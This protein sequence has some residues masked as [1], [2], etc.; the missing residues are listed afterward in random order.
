MN[1]ILN[2]DLDG[3]TLGAQTGISSRG[4]GFR[5]GFDAAF[6]TDFADGRGHFMIGGE[7]LDDEGVDTGGRR[8]RP[9][10]GAGLV[11]IGG[12]QLELQPDVNDLAPITRGGTVLAGS[13]AGQVF[14]PDGSLRPTSEADF[15]SLYDLL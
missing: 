7:Y 5:Y 9:W 13:F 10:L 3:V 11:N 4:D 8:E 6:G 12:G 14:N 2:D 1:I 15:F